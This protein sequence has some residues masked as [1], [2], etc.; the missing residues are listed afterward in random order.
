MPVVRVHH[1]RQRSSPSLLPDRER[2]AAQRGEAEGVVGEGAVAIAVQTPAVEEL[3]VGKHA[4]ARGEVARRCRRRLPAQPRLEHAELP[5]MTEPQMGDDGTAPPVGVHGHPSHAVLWRHDHHVYPEGGQRA[6]KGLDD[7]AEPSR[8]G[9]RLHLGRDHQDAPGTPGA[10]G[11]RAWIQEA[12]LYSVLA[13]T[14]TRRPPSAA[15]AAATR[16][17]G[18]K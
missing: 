5:G 15:P 11:D 13:R 3:R 17:I 14:A 12:A 7:V 8:P 16:S 10:L 4:C 18:R 6:R 9:E 2:A 1:V